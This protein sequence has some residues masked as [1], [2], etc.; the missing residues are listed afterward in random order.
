MY[1]F[2]LH[3][4]YAFVMELVDILVLG[5]SAPRA[6]RFESDRRQAPTIVGK[7]CMFILSKF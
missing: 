5:T 7:I 6:C 1:L 3:K 4:H 2:D